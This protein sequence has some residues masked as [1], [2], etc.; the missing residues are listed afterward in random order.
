MGWFGPSKEQKHL[1]LMREAKRD[2]LKGYYDALRLEE[3][4]LGVSLTHIQKF[5]HEAR[6]AKSQ[7][8]EIVTFAGQHEVNEALREKSSSMVHDMER[9]TK[10]LLTLSSGVRDSANQFAHDLSLQAKRFPKEIKNCPRGLSERSLM[11]IRK[12]FSLMIKEFRRFYHAWD[13][14]HTF[15]EKNPTTRSVPS[16]GRQLKDLH[17]D[18]PI[19]FKSRSIKDLMG[20]IDDTRRDIDEL[21]RLERSA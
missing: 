10:P 14:I 11:R 15:V 4:T 6:S 8:G 7:I 1:A 20:S 16:W 2:E 12:E 21:E 3:K 5:E 9:F 19:A 18:L 17:E 13:H